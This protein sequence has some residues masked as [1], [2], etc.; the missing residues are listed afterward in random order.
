MK[1]IAL[2]L[3]L[4][5]NAFADARIRNSN[6]HPSAAIVDTKLATISTSGKVAN[7]ATTATK[8]NTGSTIVLRDPSGVA[9]I[10]TV[11]GNIIG[12]VTGNVSGAISG[13]AATATAL[14]ANPT[15]CAANTYATA[16]DAEADLTCSQVNASAGITGTLPVANGGTGQVTANAALN[17]LLPSQTS[18]TGKVLTTDGVNTS[19]ATASGGSGTAYNW[20]G[21]ISREQNFDLGTPATGFQNFTV[22]NSAS[23]TET[24]NDNFGSVTIYNSGGN[25]PGIVFTCP[26]TKKYAFFINS[27]AACNGTNNRNYYI[28]AT[29]DGSTTLAFSG[30]RCTNTTTQD[31]ETFIVQGVLSCTAAASV[32]LWLQEDTIN[33]G[34][35]DANLNGQGTTGVDF[36][37]H[38]I[39]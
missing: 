33:S 26:A 27:S 22:N 21:Y 13:N 28:R 14:A 3:L 37:I 4:S 30:G 24:A 38:N 16:A 6:I 8:D 10:G 5:T 20:A 23:L 31:A 29:T 15:D 32:N 39:N 12:N 17:A 1:F 19:W 9:S 7:S 35:P 36:L 25:L 34:G 2:L 18:S 11:I